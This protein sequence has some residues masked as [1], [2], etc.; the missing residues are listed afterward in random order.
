MKLALLQVILTL[1]HWLDPQK[2]D[3]G[4]NSLKDWSKVLHRM[5]NNSK[6]TQWILKRV[7]TFKKDWFSHKTR[8]VFM[9]G[10]VFKDRSRNSAI[11]KMELF[12]A[13]TN[14]RKL[15]RAS[16]NK[17]QGFWMCSSFQRFS[18]LYV[19]NLNPQ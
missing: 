19:T 16:S 5:V 13:V 6:E 3:S 18:S 14:G 4:S 7:A 12:V 10:K 15:Q 17:S 9:Q 1:N 2:Q 11:F 8:L